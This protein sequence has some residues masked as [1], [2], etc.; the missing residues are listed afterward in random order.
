MEYTKLPSR[1]WQ[2]G[3]AYTSV[4][5]MA[6]LIN[7]YFRYCE[8]NKI[9][10]CFVGISQYLG[11]AQETLRKYGRGDYDTE[12]NKFSDLITVAKDFTEHDKVVNGLNG[13]YNS[14]MTKFV[15]ENNYGWAEKKAVEHTV[16]EPPKA[17]E[18][19]KLNPNADP[20]DAYRL[21]QE[22]CRQKI[23]TEDV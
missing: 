19:A 16:K 17:E 11:I 5:E 14:N 2:G 12:I 23:L 13:T 7:E 22:E 9:P 6:D 8:E 15:L 3:R 21:W 1:P 18:P 10:T 4:Q 20:S